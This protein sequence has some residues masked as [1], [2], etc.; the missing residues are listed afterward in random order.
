MAPEA[1]GD[2][3]PEGGEQTVAPVDDAHMALTME[4]P[5]DVLG[6]GL[7]LHEHGIV[8]L[9]VKQVGIDEA[10]TNIGEADIQV[11]LGSELFEGLEIGGLQSFG[12]GIRG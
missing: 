2:A 10:G 4:G 7:G 3:A 6:D 5:D 1:A 8:E 12:G 11:L 9:T